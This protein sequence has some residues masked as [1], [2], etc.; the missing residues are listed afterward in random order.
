M[1]IIWYMFPVQWEELR[2][3]H[4]TPHLV[5]SDNA[6]LHLFGSCGGHIILRTSS[7]LFIF[8]LGFHIEGLFG[9]RYISIYIL[10][11]QIAFEGH[12]R[13]QSWTLPCKCSLRPHSRWPSPTQCEGSR[14]FNPP[15]TNWRATHARRVF[16]H[17]Q[18][19]EECTPLRMC[20]DDHNSE[21]I[22]SIQRWRWRVALQKATIDRSASVV[23]FL[24]PGPTVTTLYLCVLAAEIQ[25]AFVST[26]VNC[27]HHWT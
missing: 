3:N 17:I 7:D 24:R 6:L 5:A 11:G 18:A 20:T 14:I 16:A 26:L 1:N 4:L 13:L 23:Y 15:A 19:P 12:C 22:H 2:L 9:E 21:L 8:N 25:L 10:K 27:K